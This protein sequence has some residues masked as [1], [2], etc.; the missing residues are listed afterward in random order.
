MFCSKNHSH[1]YMYV[2]A[3]ENSVTLLVII[4]NYIAVLRATEQNTY[5]FHNAHIIFKVAG[6]SCVLK[7]S[8]SSMANYGA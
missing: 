2:P 8:I 5:S 1:W 3:M 4:I 6:K 7:T